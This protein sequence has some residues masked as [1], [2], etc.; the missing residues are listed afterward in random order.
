[1]SSLGVQARIRPGDAMTGNWNPG[2]GADIGRRV[3]RAFDLA[4]AEPSLRTMAAL[5]E[6][7]ITLGSAMHATALR[8]ER[9]VI[10]LKELLRGHGGPGWSP[11]IATGRGIVPLRREALVYAELF[12]W[13][14]AAYYAER[15]PGL[16]AWRGRPA[17]VNA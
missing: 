16:S 7:T 2:S 11:S 6:A 10:M 5:R 1:M 17:R 13:W 3:V 8:P 9:A 12:T 14:V 4:V 15:S